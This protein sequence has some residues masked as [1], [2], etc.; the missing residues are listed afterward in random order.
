MTG[1]VNIRHRVL[2]GGLV[3]PVIDRAMVDRAEQAVAP[4]VCCDECCAGD[5][6]RVLAKAALRGALGPDLVIDREE[7]TP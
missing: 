4:L 6:A 2:G 7:A 1:R 5:G 3:V